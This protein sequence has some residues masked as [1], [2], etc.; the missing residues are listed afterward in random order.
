MP[1]FLHDFVVGIDVASEF[2][3][4]A[5]LAPDGELIRKPFRID[6]NP[7]GFNYLL[8]ILKKETEPQVDLTKLH[9]KIGEQALEIEFLEGVLKKLGRFNHKS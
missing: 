3:F 9:A 6:H 4:V 8:Q 5:M 7:A 1:K 2:S